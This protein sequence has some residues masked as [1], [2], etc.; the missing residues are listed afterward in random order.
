MPKDRVVVGI[1]IGSSKVCTLIA[2]AVES[3]LV[4]IIGSA[5]VPSSGIKKTQ[6]VDID[7]AVKAI[8]AS[9][10]AAERMAGYSVSS[11]FVGAGGTHITC[12][13]SH[14][15][16]A[17]AEPQGEIGIDD[18]SRVTEAAQAI[19]LP[20]DREILHVLP[21][22]FIVD[23]QEGIKDPIGMTGVRLEVDTHIIS[24]AATT[25]RNLAK[26][27]SEIGID[28]EALVFSGLASSEAVLSETEKELGVIL[29][30]LGGGT[31]DICMFVDGALAHSAVI[32]V[33]AKNITADLAIG[34][35]VSL[36][37]AEKIK[38]FFSQPPKTV[39]KPGGRDKT[40]EKAKN[41]EMDLS[42]LSL[43]EE[44]KTVSKKTLFEGIIKPRLM[45]IFSLVEMEIKKS[46]FAGLTP[47]GI[48]LCG[49]GA[50]TKGAVEAAKKVLAMPV[51]ISSPQKITGLID[52]IS[53]PEFAAS[54][55]LVLYGVR[56][57]RKGGRLGKGLPLGR[58]QFGRIFERVVNFIKSFLP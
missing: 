34:L 52:E 56:Q 37:S 22:N 36:D 5:I 48:V 27:V 15:V 26:C 24:G 16:V 20:S 42:P 40:G 46:G 31:T 39:A 43:P 32:P 7:E 13:N 11:A 29:V 28:I 14:G 18:V 44:L 10:E 35:R 54:V 51:H 8:M 30:D 9:V 19:S 57:E 45:E 6:V 17:V 55:G 41:E 58:D 4:N 33:G 53:A 47:A 1:D 23:S 50:N 25:M 21:R 2:T 3:G 12:Q 49:G 38:L